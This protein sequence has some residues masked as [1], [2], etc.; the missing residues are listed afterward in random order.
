MGG[1]FAEIV[2]D[3]WQ[4]LSGPMSSFVRRRF[5]IGGFFVHGSIDQSRRPWLAGWR[6]TGKSGRARN[7]RKIIVTRLGV[8]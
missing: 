5:L 4:E 3:V 6:S 2:V 7:A 1:E 8:E